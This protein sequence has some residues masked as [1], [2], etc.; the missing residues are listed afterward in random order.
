MHLCRLRGEDFRLFRTIEF[1]PQPG[2]T[3]I[4]DDN[5]AGK[6]SLLEAV[7]CAGRGRSFRGEGS[8]ELA[9]TGTD[10]WA[11]AAELTYP[12]RPAYSVRLIWSDDRTQIEADDMREIGRADLARH[13]PIEI[14]EVHTHELVEGAPTLRR[15]YLDWGVFH[16]EQRFSSEWGRYNRALQQ[17]NRALKRARRPSE[18]RIWDSELASAGET[19]TEFR[20]AHLIA[21][22][23][24]LDHWLGLLLAE[25]GWKIELARGWPADRPLV[26]ALT[27][28]FERD[29]RL[30]ITGDGPH[31][32][33]LRVR[34]SGDGAQERLSRGQQKLLVAAL[35][36]AQAELI[37]EGNGLTPLILVDDFPAE[38]G[39]GFQQRL[40]DALVA[41][42]GQVL[43]TALDPTPA[44]TELKCQMFH[45]EQSL[46]H[47]RST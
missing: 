5:G 27:D 41:Y 9:R 42:G 43:I 45:V 31:R 30:G 40:R 32:A 38:L 47:R 19:L 2:I 22:A 17:R 10:R 8:R 1:A 4:T 24:R 46:L 39:L 16:V 6:T 15:R 7:F 14:I 18:I 12:D 36:L 23:R 34:R 28:H 33:E 44:L 3:L 13:F 11:L 29:R 25:S 37:R 20:Q 26:G 35:V 21:L